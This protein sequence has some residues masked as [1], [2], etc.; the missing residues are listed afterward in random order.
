MSK[1]LL[2]IIAL[3]CLT[4]SSAWADGS[5]GDGV[6]W[7]YDAGTLTISYSGH[8]TGVM[9]DY[10]RPDDQPWKSNRG[11]ITSIVIGSGVTHIGAR[12]FA[13]CD[14][15][16]LT[17]ITI[18][19]SVTTIGT[20]SFVNCTGLTSVTIPA[21]V[22]SIGDGAFGGCTGLTSVTFAAESQLETI[23]KDA[24]YNCNNTS[25]T[26]ITIPASVTTIGSRAFMN[27]TG[28]T[29]IAIPA[30]VTTIG[31]EAFYKCTGLTSINVDAA[32]ANYA[33]EDGVLFNKTKTT[34]I[35][36]PPSKSGTAYTIPASVTSIGVGAFSDCSNLA[37]VTVYATT[38]TLG[39][40]AFTHCNSLAN[41]YVFSDRETY[42][43]G[44]DKWSTYSGIISPLTDLNG[45]CGATDHVSD[46]KWVLTGTS[47]NYTLTIMKTGE[48]GAMAD[49]TNA[50]DRPWDSNV[51]NIVCPQQIGADNL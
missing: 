40:A 11:D 1:K 24:F 42:Y 7:S 18:P 47:P 14:N 43:E 36:Y 5:C 34:I 20:S 23:G 37:T 51:S 8:G 6:T 39:A 49:Y 16:S 50:T 22:T 9:A 45:T 41:I 2:S 26:T 4:V 15:A 12:A 35:Q 28:L 32:N 48:T 29:S 46:V 38:C 21:N 31:S 13:N 30:N 25:L 10:D 33:S 27:C 17:T 44:A 19:A 3:L